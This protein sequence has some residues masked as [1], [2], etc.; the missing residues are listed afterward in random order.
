[1]ANMITQLNPWV[2]L[3]VMRVQDGTSGGGTRTISARGAAMAIRSA[4]GRK[5]DIISLSW[6]ILAKGRTSRPHADGPQR[7]VN[8][9]IE[10]LGKAIDEAVKARILIFCSAS[11]D[12]ETSALDTL[13][14]QQAPD[15][16]FRIGAASRHGQRDPSSEDAQRINFY[17]PGNMV[18]EAVDPTTST[19]ARLHTGASVST[20]LATGLASLIIYC[21]VIVRNHHESEG[22]VSSEFARKADGLKERDQL[23][24]AFKSITFPGWQDAKFLP[25]WDFFRSTSSRI[26]TESGKAKFKALSELVRKVS[27]NIF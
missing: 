22:L 5:V 27:K 17:F 21:A 19:Q 12:I 14:Y 6:T 2:S 24:A 11:D 4:I 16:I 7:P 3:C 23:D 25:I 8:K 15:Y 1:M 9:D 18:E 20:A 26:N 13:P 10:E